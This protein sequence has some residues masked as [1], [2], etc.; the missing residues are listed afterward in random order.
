[1]A[2]R[3]GVTWEV[4]ALQYGRSKSYPLA[5]M[6]AGEEPGVMHPMGWFCWVLRRGRHAVIVDTGFHADHLLRRWCVTPVAQVQ[7]LLAELNIDPRE[8][9]DVV[10]TH[11]H[12]D[13][14]GNLALFSRARIWMR[15]AEFMYVLSAM[16]PLRDLRWGVSLAD[17][18]SM[19]IAANEDRLILLGNNQEPV[20]PGV[21]LC[22]GGGHTP[23]SQ[24][25]EVS[26]AV[27]TLV[28]ASDNAYLMRN[29]AELQPVGSCVSRA[30]NEAALLRMRRSVS[31]LRRVIPGHDPQV[32]ELF[33]ESARGVYRLDVPLPA[34]DTSRSTSIN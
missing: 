25:V 9:G 31:D 7:E 4:Y 33:P 26:T 29:V 11:G 21:L 8:V 6:V 32:A 16:G 34:A 12:A 17:Y 3:D 23:G 18:E 24:W 14:T 15:E 19:L 20:L 13:H 27:G 22:P 1:M 2:E 10:L 30:Q 28:L 5:D